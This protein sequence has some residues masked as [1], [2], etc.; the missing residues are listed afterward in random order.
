[1]FFHFW[2]RD[3][4][5]WNW[6]S[7]VNW[8]SWGISHEIFWYRHKIYHHSK[9][10]SVIKVNFELVLMRL[11]LD[12]RCIMNMGQWFLMSYGRSWPTVTDDLV[13]NAH[14]GLLEE[15]VLSERLQGT[16]QRLTLRVNLMDLSLWVV[17]VSRRRSCLPDKLL[18][19]LEKQYNY[20][21]CHVC[22]FLPDY[23]L[24]GVMNLF[25]MKRV[26]TLFILQ[27]YMVTVALIGLLSNSLNLFF[28]LSTCS[29]QTT[30]L[31]ME[32]LH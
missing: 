10:N 23:G 27:R 24:I 9:I 25:G 1:M 26:Q 18:Q 12:V 15:A 30:I 31:F 29:S 32:R 21:S 20:P 22:L 6:Q 3:K 17:Q 14:D 2:Y 5:V 16:G 19:I 8:N 4:V 13:G 28:F 11:I 7:S